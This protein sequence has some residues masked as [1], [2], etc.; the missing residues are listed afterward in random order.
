LL[1]AARI[2]EAILLERLIYPTA[3]PEGFKGEWKIWG[4]VKE[5]VEAFLGR[6]IP[7]KSGQ[8]LGSIALACGLPNDKLTS[9]VEAPEGQI[10]LDELIRRYPKEAL[11]PLGGKTLPF[12]AKFLFIDKDPVIWVGLKD[13][14]DIDEVIKGLTELKQIREEYKKKYNAT[15]EKEE[16]ERLLGEYLALV[17]T[18]CDKYFNRIDIRER[19]RGLLYL[20]SGVIHALDANKDGFFL[21]EP[22]QVSNDTFQI[23]L[24]DLERDFD[25]QGFQKGIKIIRQTDKYLPRGKALLDYLSHYPKEKA[26][27]AF[28][29]IDIEPKQEISIEPAQTSPMTLLVYKGKLKE[30][31]QTEASA[32]TL[33]VG[34]WVFVPYAFRE[35]IR[36]TNETDE[37]AEVL[38]VYAEAALLL[39]E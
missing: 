25:E 4:W 9:T 39:Q 28:D 11:G 8:R 13:D 3:S 7:G 10:Q 20:E 14:A 24:R 21:L 18:F 26:K 38:R 16:K 2:K 35:N 31:T 6:E 23:V 32:K 19:Q 17:N 22:Q 15:E 36:L 1:S 27:F 37:T 12:Y 34:D 5:R 30:S 33:G 29:T